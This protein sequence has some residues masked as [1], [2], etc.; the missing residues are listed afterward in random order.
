MVENIKID[1]YGTKLTIKELAN[2]IV[3]DP[4][5]LIIKVWD[6]NLVNSIAKKIEES[7]LDL[8]PVIEGQNIILLIPPMVEERK[9]ELI[10]LLHQKSEQARIRIRQIRE[11][12]WKKI[13]TLEK[14]KKIREDDKFKA[15]DELQ[16][17]VD[18]FNKKIEELIE[19]KEKELMA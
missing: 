5:S 19:K 13:Q 4:K 2:I 8:N 1:A 9:K 12:V 6:K 10:K 11:E 18:E 3:K 7:N 14:E 17:V 15:K 16:K